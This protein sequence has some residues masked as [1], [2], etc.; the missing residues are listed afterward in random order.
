[1]FLQQRCGLYA[2]TGL[3]EYAAL[4]VLIL[5]RLQVL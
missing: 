3:E 2:V 5:P 4:S 1:M